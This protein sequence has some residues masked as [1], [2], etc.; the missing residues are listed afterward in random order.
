MKARE[1]FV[2]QPIATSSHRHIATLPVFLHQTPQYLPVRFIQTPRGVVRRE[3]DLVALD[4]GYGILDIVPDDTK[5]MQGIE[6]CR[7]SNIGGIIPVAIPII[8]EEFPVEEAAGIHFAAGRHVG[9]SHEISLWYA[10][11][12]FQPAQQ[13][14]QTVH[15]HVCKGLE[16]IIVDLNTNTGTVQVGSI[17]P[18]ADAGMLGPEIIVEHM[19]YH[20]ITADHIV[21]AYSSTGQREGLER[22]VAAVLRRMV[23]HYKVGTADTKIGG[24]GKERCL[25]GGILQRIF[26]EQLYIFLYLLFIDPVGAT[27]CIMRTG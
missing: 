5:G 11:S 16:A 14:E 2:R 20:P 1:R 24:S 6:L 18:A 21:G 13:F 17:A 15:L 12:P 26:T 8:S 3:M 27:V 19:K 9:M 22:L 7:N 10:V 4:R 25:L 23:D